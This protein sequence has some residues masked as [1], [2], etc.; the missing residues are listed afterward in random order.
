VSRDVWIVSTNGGEPRQLTTHASQDVDPE[1]SPDGQTLY[2]S[3]NRTGRF[4][5]FAMPVAGGEA[6]QLTHEGGERPVVTAD[7]SAIVFQKRGSTSGGHDAH[8]ELWLLPVSGAPR[9]LNIA[10]YTHA[11]DVAGGEATPVFAVSPDGSTIFFQVADQAGMDLMML[12][13]F[14]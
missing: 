11:F 4:E 2:F 10:G 12:D 3:S 5:L 14:R 1:L 9:S 8:R 6:T 7:G 13:P